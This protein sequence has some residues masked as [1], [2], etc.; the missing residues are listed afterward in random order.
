MIACVFAAVMRPWSLHFKLFVPGWLGDVPPRP[1]LPVH[2]SE[3]LALQSVSASLSQLFAH[4]GNAVNT[5]L[6]IIIGFLLLRFVLRRTWA[7]VIVSVAITAVVWGPGWPYLGWLTM[8]VSFSL[9]FFLFFRYGW[10][11]VVVYIFIGDTLNS[12][13]LTVDASAWYAHATYLATAVVMA[14]TLYGFH[15]SLGGRA[16]LG[17]LLAE[18]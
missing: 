11:T 3:F 8:L 2:A 15:F 12:F 18:E 16:A 14:V 6:F 1:D 5:S 10:V 9:W 4:A 17:D 7:A 13:P